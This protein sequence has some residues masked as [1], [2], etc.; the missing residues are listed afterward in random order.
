MKEQFQNELD[1]NRRSFSPC[2]TFFSNLKDFFTKK[3]LPF[4]KLH[5]DSKESAHCKEYDIQGI[6]V[7]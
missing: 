6:F 1:R 3:H 7:K 2:K 5:L 4:R